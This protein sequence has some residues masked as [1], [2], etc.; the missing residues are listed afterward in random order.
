M[1]A[2]IAKDVG[3]AATIIIGLILI[4]IMIIKEY[5]KLQAAR[6]KAKMERAERHAHALEQVAEQLKYLGMQVNS[7]CSLMD[8][9]AG[10]FVAIQQD[11]VRLDKRCERHGNVLARLNGGK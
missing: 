8:K 10:L 1:W 2:A 5:P 9:L 3:I 11:I 7:L 4:A 6:D